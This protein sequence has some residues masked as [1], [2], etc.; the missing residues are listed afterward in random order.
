MSPRSLILGGL[1]K[2]WRSRRLGGS[3]SDQLLDSLLPTLR[4]RD[5]FD[6]IFR[7]E[8]K[9][10]AQEQFHAAHEAQIRHGWAAE[11]AVFSKLRGR[12]QNRVADGGLS[13]GKSDVFV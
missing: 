3:F 6:H 4:A 5:P 8:E 10:P 11:P 1:E 9:Y 13:A 2:S 7:Q 12:V